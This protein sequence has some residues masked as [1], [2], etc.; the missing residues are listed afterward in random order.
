MRLDVALFALRLFKS[1]SQA[2]DAI[3]RGEV[4]LNATPAKA[5]HEL[6]AG[7]R[8]TLVTPGVRRT[9]EVLELPRRSLS[10]EAARQMVREV[11]DA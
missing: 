4:L 2:Q 5:S 7:D 6:R 3:A 8:V 11:P 9:V 10:R 1:R